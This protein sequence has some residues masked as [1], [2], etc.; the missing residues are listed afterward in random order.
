VFSTQDSPVSQ[1]HGG[2]QGRNPAVN[3]RN[4]RAVFHSRRLSSI[5]QTA[6]RSTGDTDMVATGRLRVGGTQQA[7]LDRQT[8]PNRFKRPER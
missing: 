5:S 7:E 6:G 4:F 8:R 3:G 1:F 2:Q